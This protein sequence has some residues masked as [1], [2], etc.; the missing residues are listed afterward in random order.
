LQLRAN[1]KP[2]LGG[3]AALMLKFVLRFW[4]PR[5]RA[6]P[7]PFAVWPF[8]RTIDGQ[9]R[10]KTGQQRRILPPCRTRHDARQSTGTAQAAPERTARI[11]RVDS[12]RQTIR[13]RQ[14]RKR[15]GN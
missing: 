5:Y 14:S 1:S 7:R 3:F 8:P 6:N 12:P 10:A 4:T 9:F 2:L 13:A 15:L 11:S